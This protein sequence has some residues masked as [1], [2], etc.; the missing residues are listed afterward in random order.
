MR[1]HIQF[2]VVYMLYIVVHSNLIRL[3]VSGLVFGLPEFWR[4][5]LLISLV[6]ELPGFYYQSSALYVYASIG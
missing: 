2:F 6:A 3:V 4:Y 1:K 5:N